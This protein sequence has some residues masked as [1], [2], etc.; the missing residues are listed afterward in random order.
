[1]ADYTSGKTWQYMDKVGIM[2]TGVKSFKHRTTVS[3]LH[4][5]CMYY[6][7][8]LD[9]LSSNPNHPDR[10]C[11]LTLGWVQTVLHTALLSVPEADLA[12][13]EKVEAIG[14]LNKVRSIVRSIMYI[15]HPSLGALDTE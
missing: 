12:M 7:R 1:M 13:S 9:Y 3:P 10:D 15:T 6:L 5:P 14:A 8:A 11:A 4:V 2:H